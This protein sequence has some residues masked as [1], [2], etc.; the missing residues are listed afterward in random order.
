M[1]EREDIK[2]L[3]VSVI[4]IWFMISMVVPVYAATG[5][6]KAWKCGDSY[7][8]PTIYQSSPQTY[9]AKQPACVT[10]DGTKVCTAEVPEYNPATACA[11]RCKSRV[12][13]Q[14]SM[15]VKEQK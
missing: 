4:A 2:S 15:S 10:P 12:T 7:D 9:C 14:P 5:A 8:I 3:L 13:Q 6:A 1:K 11:A